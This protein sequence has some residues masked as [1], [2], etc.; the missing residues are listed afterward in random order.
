ML[1]FENDIVLVNPSTN[2]PTSSVSASSVCTK[3]FKESGNKFD[4]GS[5]SR[6]CLSG[7]FDNCWHITRV[8]DQKS[9]L[10]QPQPFLRNLNGEVA[11]LSTNPLPPPSKKAIVAPDYGTM[12]QGDPGPSSTWL[13]DLQSTEQ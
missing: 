10:L 3:L 6:N 8:G 9:I 2:L 1:R 5:V 13:P 4:W 12:C 7:S 11:G